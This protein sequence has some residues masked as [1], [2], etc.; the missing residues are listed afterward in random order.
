M[1]HRKSSLRRMVRSVHV[2]AGDF[3][4]GVRLTMPIQL[5]VLFL[6]LV[7]EDQNLVGAALLDHLAGDERLR[8]LAQFALGAAERQHLVELHGFSASLRQFLD[9]N[10]VAG[11]DAI[12]LSPG[13]DHRVHGNA[14][15][16]FLRRAPQRFAASP[17][18]AALAIR[19]AS[20][21]SLTA[22]TAARNSQT[23]YVRLHSLSQ[24]EAF[25]GPK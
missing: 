9:L 14:S 22:H 25:T 5:L 8:R 21:A 17:S 13:A 20:S 2:D 11:C 10:N 4:G 24:K 19:R 3:H 18:P 7:V 12:L 23:G 15:V 1:C 6:A 16:A